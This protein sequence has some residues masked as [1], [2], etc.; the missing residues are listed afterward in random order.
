MR[1]ATTT[2]IKKD[3]SEIINELQTSTEIRSL[4]I[5]QLIQEYNENYPQ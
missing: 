2:K 4:F 3:E 1:H 5:V